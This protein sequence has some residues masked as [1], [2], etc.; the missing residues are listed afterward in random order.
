MGYFLALLVQ[1]VILIA[2][3]AGI[4]RMFVKA[5][6]PGWEAIV[7][8]YNLYVMLKIAGRPGWWLILFFIPLAGIVMAFVLN[9]DLAKKFG[10][11]IL[12]GL[13]M[14]V[15]PFICYPVLGFSDA[16]YTA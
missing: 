2:L 14:T 12:F 13:C 8:I 1:L 3:V 6:R 11:D 4:W 10:K 5:G 16:R 9:I 15:F 7:P